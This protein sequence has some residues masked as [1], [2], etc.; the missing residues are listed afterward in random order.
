MSY[1]IG[2][3]VIKGNK[4]DLKFLCP[5]K[6]ENID[7]Q[8]DID[9]KKFKFKDPQFDEILAKLIDNDIL[10]DDNISLINYCKS[11]YDRVNLE[12]VLNGSSTISEALDKRYDQ[13]KEDLKVFKR[14]IRNY[15]PDAY[16]LVFRET[17]D[18]SKDAT[19]S[20]Y[21]GSSISSCKK[22]ISHS[23]K[24]INEKQFR[25][26]AQTATKE[27][28]IK[29]VGELIKK[30]SD[31]A[32]QSDDYKYIIKKLEDETF[33]EKSR[34]KDNACFPNQLS[35]FELKLILERQKSSFPEFLTDEN[36]D[37]II[38][39]NEFR[40]PYY[41][42]PLSDLHSDKNGFAWIKRTNPHSHE[43]ITPWN[44]EKE[45]DLFASGEEFIA[46]M[47]SRCTYLPDQKVLPAQSL[48]YQEYLLLNDLNNLKINGERITQDLKDFLYTN[49]CQ[50]EERI[51]KAK[52]RKELLNAKK[53]SENDILGQSD[54]LEIEFQSSL[55][56]MIKCK[57]ILDIGDNQRLTTQQREM[58][59]RII[60]WL[61]VFGDEKK[62]VKERITKEYGN[63]LSPEQIKQFWVCTKNCGI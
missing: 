30:S 46:R 55:S 19:Y 52:I 15:M 3:V 23:K 9:L 7:E 14:F 56:S 31:E 25:H 44:F 26:Y 12:I 37:K 63:E 36:I 22:N 24:C 53:I 60:T 27:E 57:K 5:E 45:V 48:L 50:K 32:K 16:D 54:K 1:T 20:H 51:T 59:E 40:I 17:S 8:F 29:F 34:I 28:F 62:P 42:G 61:T 43:C 18:S 39:L 47:I 49:L 10:S 6:F 11:F 35:T 41:V 58:C 33:C 2:K 38:K 21:I 4:I 13:H